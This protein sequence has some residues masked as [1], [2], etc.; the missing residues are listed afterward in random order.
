MIITNLGHKIFVRYARKPIWMPTAPSKLFRIPEHTFYDEEEVKQIRQLH[1]AFRHQE[2][3]IQEFMRQ[4][5]YMPSLQAG[6]LPVEF[7][8]KEVEEDRQLFEENNRENERIG[9]LRQKMMDEILKNLETKVME[10]KL[11]KEEYL[12][13]KAMETDEYIK[14]VK[15]D[16]YS[17]VT[18]DNIEECIENA[19]QNPVSFSFYIDSSGNHYK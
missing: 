6:G 19:I 5:F 16:P 13:V 9:K 3:S 8:E 1:E 7:I 18:P 10:E 14:A 15:S 17:F 4:E 2:R 11:R 12:M